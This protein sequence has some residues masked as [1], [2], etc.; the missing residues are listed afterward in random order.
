[1]HFILNTLLA[2]L[3]LG[4]V[5]LLYIYMKQNHI[6]WSLE[7]ELVGEA[8]SWLKYH[9]PLLME[10]SSIHCYKVTRKGHLFYVTLK[11]VPSGY[12]DRMVSYTPTVSLLD[13]GDKY[14]GNL[15]SGDIEQFAL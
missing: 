9:Y 14:T 2:L 10:Q 15:V 13:S 4:S 5:V 6:T 11:V 3:T 7:A 1:M 12:G 8:K